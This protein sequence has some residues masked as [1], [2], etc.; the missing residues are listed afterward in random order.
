L[1]ILENCLLQL[2]GDLS[3]KILVFVPEGNRSDWWD[4][5][6]ARRVRATHRWMSEEDAGGK[7][8]QQLGI[9]ASGGVVIVGADRQLLYL[10][11]LRSAKNCSDESVGLQIIQQALGP[12]SQITTG[13]PVFG[14]S[15]RTPGSEGNSQDEI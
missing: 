6:T 11:G 12:V 9:K 4:S 8:A 5:P 15:L 10:G 14:C 13:L 7:L 2:E 3:C 1:E